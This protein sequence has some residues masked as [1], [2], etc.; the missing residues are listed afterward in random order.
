MGIREMSSRRSDSKLERHRR[1]QHHHQRRHSSNSQMSRRDHRH[2]TDPQKYLRSRSNFSLILSQA[3]CKYLKTSR[4]DAEK[5]LRLY[6][7]AYKQLE[8]KSQIGKQPGVGFRNMGN[9][10]FMNTTLQA[11]INTPRIKDIF[12]RDVFVKNVNE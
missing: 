7:F 3:Y 1:H 10:C 5:L 12:T 2:R 8:S 4:V 6:S 9:T 11:I